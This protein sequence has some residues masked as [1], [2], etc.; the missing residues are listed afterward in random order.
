MISVVITISLIIFLIVL[1]MI[2]A[3]RITKAVSMKENVEEK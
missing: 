2:R 3:N 1:L